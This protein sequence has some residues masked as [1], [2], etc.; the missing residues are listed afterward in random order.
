MQL[1]DRTAV[2]LQGEN[3]TLKSMYEAV[4]TTAPF[5]HPLPQYLI[6]TRAGLEANS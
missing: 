3:K 2:S 5:P 1:K 4:K 6:K